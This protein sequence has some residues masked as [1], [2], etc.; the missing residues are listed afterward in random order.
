MT[1]TEQRYHSNKKEFLALKWAVTKQFHEYLYPYRNNKMEFVVRTDNNPLTYIFSS[2]SL[3]AAGQRWVGKLADYNFSLEYQKGKDNTVADFLSWVEDH[4][5]PSEVEECLATIPQPGV[6]AI[7]NNAVK[8]IEYRVEAGTQPLQTTLA[9][10]LEAHPARLSTVHV[11]DWKKAQKEDPVLYQVVKNLKAPREQ[12]KEALKPLIEKKSV[13]DYVKM[14]DRLVLKDGLLYLKTYEGKAKEV[15]FRFVVPKAHHSKALDGCHREA[16]H[17]GQKHSL[18]LLS[19]CFWWL[20]MS[21]ELVKRVKMCPHCRKFE[22][23]LP[24]AKLQPLP[25]SG[26]GEILHIDFTSIEESVDLQ[27]APAIRNIL[28][29]QDHFSKYMVAYVVKDQMAATAAHT[30]RHGYF[31]LFGVPAYLVSDQGKAFVSQIVKDLCKLYG[32]QKLRTSPYH[33]QTNGQVERMNQTI[34]RMIGKLGEDQKAH[35][36]EHLPELL[37]AY[38]ATCSVVTGYTPYYLL[39]GRRPR[40]PVDFQFPTHRDPPDTT[41]MARSVA[42]MQE[43]LKEAFEVARQ[44]TSEEAARQHRYYD[45]TARA[46]SLQPGD[47]VMVRMDW[48]VGKRKVKDWWE[49]GGYVI[50]S[51]LEDWP[52]Y[53]VRCPPSGHRRN[54]SYKFLHWNRLLLM[55]PEDASDEVQDN[56]QPSVDTPT[57]SNATLRAFLVGVDSPESEEHLPSLVTRQVGEQT[58]WVWLNGEFR[59]RPWTLNESLATQ[60]PPDSHEGDV[61]EPELGL[62]DS[63]AEE[64]EVT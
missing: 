60:S 57:I 34:I 52:V 31:A 23:A 54:P 41:S 51:Q 24:K 49:E 10:A 64:A 25:C 7:L 50:V 37:L 62:P 6:K 3:D 45:K 28:V 8:P 42:T 14:K 39:F 33:A 22:T 19:E 9:E 27:E 47:V 32:V 40:I 13:R 18:S 44:L 48:F 35:W 21:H 30:L 26:P 29:I 1:A 36:S 11:T 38:N 16:A 59:T 53:K 63:S 12:F 61:S 46:V 17:Q 56:A 4:L 20:G 15:L 55:S 5:S 43:R 58:Q 2:T